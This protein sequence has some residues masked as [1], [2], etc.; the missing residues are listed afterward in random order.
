MDSIP[1]VLAMKGDKLTI[2]TQNVRS[3]GQGLAGRRKRKEIKNFFKLTTPT[4]DILLLQETKLPEEACLKQARYIEFRGGTS[5]WNE[6]SF[7]AQS[8]RFKGGTGIVLS[9][10][11]AAA[12]THHGI[13]YPGRAQYITI[14]LS[15]ILHIGIIN[16][17]AFSHTGARAMLWNH[18]ANVT[19]P[20]AQW[21]I[22][23][24]FNNIEHPRDKQ[25][26]S[27]NTSINT[28]ELEAW[29]QLLTRL[30]VS[31]SFNL[32]AFFRKSDKA[33]TWTNAH[34]DETMIQSRIDRVY[35]PACI[36]NIG[37]TT[38]ILPTIPDISDHAGYL[39]HFNA[40]GKKK[41]RHHPFNKGLL[42]S[43]EHKAA[44]LKEWKTVMADGQLTTWNQRMVAANQA[45][46]VKSMDLTKAQK[47]HWK[48][49]YL[50]QFEDIIAAEDELQRNW[51]SREAR[52]RLSDAQ[53]ALHEVRQEKFQFQESAI[54]S[55][56]AR[57]GDR[58]TKEFFEHHTGTRRPVS[59]NQLQEGDK[60]L[61]KQ[62]DLEAHILRFYEQ[63]YSKDEEVD[64]NFRAREDCLQYIQ[65]TVTEEH[66]EELLRTLTREEVEEAMK[67]LPTGKSPGI[68]S[69]P[70]EFYQEL[71][72]DLESD[73]FN[74]VTESINQ[75]FLAEE[76]NVSKIALLPKS[77]DRIKIQ[78]Y[79]PI[80]LLNTL[81]KIVAKVYANRMKPLLHNWILPSQ[82]GFVPNRCILDNI[83]LA[84]E[85]IAWTKENKQELSM[86]LLD[87]EKA[88]DR[89]NWT[90]LREVMAKMGFHNK[91]IEQVMSLNENAAAAVIVNGEI[92]KTF[93]LQRSVRQ[94]CP[95][96]PYLFL[97]TVDVLGQML[98]HPGCGVQGLRLPDRTMITNQMFADDTLLLLDGNRE[99]LDRALSVI[100]RFG[101]AS[102]AKLNL[103]KSVGL[104]LS[105]RNREWQWGE[106][107]G[108][109]W[110]EK[111]EV[112][113][114]LGYPFGIDIS[115]KDKDAKML[116]QIRKHLI[117]WSSNKLSLAGRIM[118]SNQ[119]I[120]A[121]IWYLASC[122]DFSGKSLKLARAAVRNYI[123]SG[124]LDSRA[125]ARVK[126]ST[127]V[128]PIVRGGVKI[129]DPEWQASALLVKLL[130]RGMS[131]GYEP[132]KTLIRYRV[133]Q[134]K[135]S[136]RGRWPAHAN[137]MMNAAHLV[138]QGSTMWQG[139][140]KAW[141]TIQSGI[142]QQD[143]QSWSEI[144]RQ[145]IFGNRFLTNEKG[146]Q[147]GT[148]VRSNMRWWSEKHVRTLQDISRPDG[149]G[150]ST[151][152]ELRRLRRTSVAPALY[153][154]VVNSIPWVATPMPAH[155][156]GQW[157]AAKE[158]DGSIQ[159]VYHLQNIT[160][161]EAKTYNKLGSDQLLLE[162][163]GQPVP[164]SAM[165][166]VRV[167]RCGG[168]KRT[169][170]DYNPQ[171]E[172]EPEQSLWLWGNDWLSNLEWDPR[173]WQWRRL[174]I[175]PETTIMN[176]TTKRGYRIAMKQNTQPMS[177]DT[178]LESE[179]YNSKARA[180]FFNRIW[181]PYLP[182]KVS[183]MQWLILT[184][185]LPVGAWRE[186]IGL[187]SS[188]ELCPLPVKETLPHAFKD[189]PQVS[190]VWVCFR[191]TRIAAGL[192]PL[193][194]TWLDISRGLMRDPV[195][196]QIEEEL[197]WDTASTFSLN[198]DT[199][200]DILRAQLLWSTWCQKVA[201][202]FRDEVF[203]IGVVLWHA[204]RNTI[205][206][207][208]EAYKE[209]FRYKRNEEKRQ[210]AIS[211][212]QQIWT[213]GSVFGRLQNRNIKW[214]ITPPPEFLPKEL[215]AWTVPPILINRLSPSPDLEAEFV[216]RPDFAN[217]VDEFIQ[218][219]GA[220]WQP[221]SPSATEEEARQETPS[222]FTSP[223]TQSSRETQR[224]QEDASDLNYTSTQRQPTQTQQAT[225]SLQIDFD[226]RVGAG[227]NSLQV[228]PQFKEGIQN[229]AAEI[230]EPQHQEPDL[231]NTTNRK[232]VVVEREYRRC[233]AKLRP[234]SR[235]KRK[236]SKRLKHPTQTQGAEDPVS[237]KGRKV[238]VNQKD[239]KQEQGHLT[240]TQQKQL[241]D[242]GSHITQNTSREPSRSKPKSRPKRKCRFGPKAR[243]ARKEK[244]NQVLPPPHPHEEDVSQTERSHLTAVSDNQNLESLATQILPDRV[245]LQPYTCQKKTP[246]SKYKVGIISEPEENPS[247][248]AAKR[249]GISVPE[250]EEALTKEIDD[251]LSEIEAKRRNAL[252]QNKGDPLSN[253]EKSQ[254]RGQEE[255]EQADPK[256]ASVDA[257]EERKQDNEHKDPVS[258]QTQTHHKS[259]AKVKCTFGP[260][261]LRG[262]EKFRTCHSRRRDPPASPPP[263]RTT[264]SSELV[265]QVDVAN[266][267]GV[268][269]GASNE[270][271]FRPDPPQSRSHHEQEKDD[272][273]VMLPDR[274]TLLNFSPTWRSPFQRF[275]RSPAADPQPSNLRPIHERLG[276]SE[277][278]FNS[279]ITEEIESILLP[280][281]QNRRSTRAL[282][283]EATPV[284]EAPPTPPPLSKEDC[285]AFFRAHGYPT[286][287]SL[288]G[289]YWWAADL[290]RARFNFDFDFDKDD[291]SIL[292]A[293][294]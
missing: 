194:F 222:D 201:H 242:K 93:R 232:D 237:Q 24:D 282:L 249:L 122:T 42:K 213:A 254:N 58:C 101:A 244:H 91:W 274:P 197:R 8:G 188:C 221:A 187:S 16:V 107:A 277:E 273:Q 126:W 156:I 160:P 55:K 253:E 177:L 57:V 27:T 252:E 150:W 115:Q 171:G 35:V 215:G 174:G 117:S 145:P 227:E 109:K 29:T 19:L 193:Y 48:E 63:L 113:R 60:L 166:E 211:C 103:H 6:S 288:L 81:Y 2:A 247:K 77:E 74:F 276:I 28:R 175:L 245:T 179:G 31:D 26:G 151:F 152:T 250:F 66:N 1:T 176:Y 229:R 118:V 272:P 258:L 83:F 157:I 94:G 127:A 180:R 217:L 199:P 110:L 72:E 129:L 98:Q 184:E 41:S 169:V 7:S 271:L 4:T 284:P 256:Y 278:T 233:T 161:L 178:Q 73:I 162:G 44:L 219:S 114:Y 102:G 135:Q 181:H 53:A 285:L 67:Q 289:V 238:G 97:L 25:G 220:N 146:V 173:E 182:R 59:I 30:G 148:E 75:S 33:F 257:P 3:L 46:R 132:W 18:L 61:T 202:S 121:S 228:E 223:S 86:L 243:Q 111:G 263:S 131:V 105:H 260:K 47:Q 88:Y 170:I 49:T 159:K 281:A 203:H 235:R 10:R 261:S 134:T 120:L 294:D 198:T 283:N 265:N 5:L 267:D 141:S 50:A 239:T 136:R 108:L 255:D 82:T 264:G 79:R 22:A 39:V 112:T 164:S 139:V 11:I 15:P 95:L 269:S 142:E 153:A 251:L 165:R 137:W 84:F 262:R 168:E 293:Y 133:A 210:E 291:L 12:V 192:P 99:N 226:Q 96:A 85:A 70:A 231:P 154:R 71:W 147:W 124:K 207:A 195:G 138:Q 246:C 191:N 52:N 56:W 13:L 216:A 248:R 287:G 32:G 14:R 196:P 163:Q 89:V 64:S 34:N 92:S 158:N 241:G 21:L 130:I 17:Y 144:I 9:E 224:S 69:I 123:W 286:N 204:W 186:R 90:F 259:R 119:V 87:F 280:A 225:L 279:R 234:C 270:V 128:L 155:Q 54:L 205:Y 23:G 45:I 189:C 183:A 43:P 51:G 218:G 290:G 190:Q 38:E 236:C 104:W 275:L 212:F 214:N 68:D 167:I 116:H 292:D 40:E 200:W 240:Q 230:H 76:L 78:N 185:G 266:S 140:M 37:G 206:C 100:N 80:S 143:P 62:T 65:T 20:E 208:M 209:L 125:R 36:E 172:I 149:W 106:E 268:T